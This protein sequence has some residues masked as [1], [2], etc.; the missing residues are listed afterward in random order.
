MCV[1]EKV[2]EQ[3]IK[4]SLKMI[5]FSSG[6]NLANWGQS[7][8]RFEKIWFKK[9][10]SPILGGSG[11]KQ[12]LYRLGVVEINLRNLGKTRGYHD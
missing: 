8:L 6:P 4:L 1:K 9:M 3:I 12:F 10:I 7:K 5:G 2:R 11:S